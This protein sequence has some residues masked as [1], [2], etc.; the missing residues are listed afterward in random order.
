VRLPTDARAAAIARLYAEAEARLQALVLE[1][2]ASGSLGTARYRSQR[3]AVVQQV[4]AA[5]QGEAVP[6]AAQAVTDAYVLGSRIAG[7]TGSFGSG[8]HGEAVNALADALTTRLNDAAET[9]GRRVD[10][11]FRREG[12]RHAAL[13]LITGGTRRDASQA[14]QDELVK[15][16]VSAFTDRAGREWGLSTYTEMVIRTTTR[17]AVSVGTKNRLLGN[18]QD[19][20]EVSKHNHEPDACTP[21]EGKTFSLTGAT[22]GYPVLDTLPPFHPMCRHVLTPAHASLEQLERSLGLTAEAV[23]A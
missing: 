13:S 18:G 9:V 5:V 20:V 4:L 7:V 3:L 17:E 8:V 21:Y 10:D 15:Q 12:L 11:V 16:G 22:D 6:Q 23:P 14:L 1:A 19:L 2:L